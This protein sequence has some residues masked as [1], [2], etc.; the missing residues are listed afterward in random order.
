MS[1]KGRTQVGWIHEGSHAK[2]TFGDLI[3]GKAASTSLFSPGIENIESHGRE[4]CPFCSKDFYSSKVMK[5]HQEAKLFCFF[6]GDLSK[7]GGLPESRFQCPKCK[8]RFSRPDGYTRHLGGARKCTGP[9][10][11]YVDNWAPARPEAFRSSE[12]L[13]V[14]PNKPSKQSP[15]RDP[16]V[17]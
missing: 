6:K 4:R 17:G 1:S 7:C 15:S 16:L 5:I 11:G 2:L 8:K 13:A 3:K 9:A 12:S 14:R 10:K